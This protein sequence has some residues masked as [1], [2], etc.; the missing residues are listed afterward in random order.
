MTEILLYKGKGLKLVGPLP[1]EV[2]NYTAYTAAPLASSSQPALAQQFVN[3]L[4][5]PVARPLF[6]A[7]GVID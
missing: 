2:Q 7:A 5:S 4:S 3:F 1:A 6:V